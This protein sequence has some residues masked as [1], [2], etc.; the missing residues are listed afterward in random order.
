M[1]HNR[2]N[3]LLRLSLNSQLFKKTGISSDIRQNATTNRFVVKIQ[4][5]NQ[6]FSMNAD[7]KEGKQKTVAINWIPIH[8]L[9]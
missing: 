1:K 8:S 6:L 3:K 2:I 4:L 9:K 7:I 5:K